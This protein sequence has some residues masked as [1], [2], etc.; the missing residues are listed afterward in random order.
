M[1]ESA[2]VG[3]ALSKAAYARQEPAL[4]DALLNAQFDLSQSGRGPVLMIISGVEGGGRSETTNKLTEWMDPRHVRVSAFGPRSCEEAERPPAWRYWR[5]LPAKGKLG[6]FLNAWYT[7]MVAARLAGTLDKTGFEFYLQETRLYERMLSDEGVVL[8]KFWIHLS[9]PALRARLDEFKRHDREHSAPY[10]LDYKRARDYRKLRPLWEEML[11]ETS[12]ADAPWTVV[13]GEDDRYRNI[14]V[15][16]VLLDAMT[17]IIPNEP[18]PA[19]RAIGAGPP[20][21]VVDNVRLVRELDLTKRLPARDYPEE[22]LKWQGRLAALTARKRFRDHALILAFEGVDAAGK[23]G[24]IRR[25]TGALDARQYVSVPIAAPTEEDKRYPYLWR[26]WRN[27]PPRGGITIFDRTWYGRVLVER[28]EGFCTEFD[29]RRAY[30]EINQFEEQ[31]VDDGGVL[32]K[33]W[34]QISKAE[35]YRRFK[36]R[37]K[38]SFKRFKIT[39]DDW[40]NRAK[41]NAYEQAVADMVDRTSSELAPWTL[42]EAEDKYFARIKILKTIVRR[43]EAAVN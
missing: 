14:T 17:R 32:C 28:V 3:H 8:L 25:V 39:P 33:F 19:R 26:F 40:R 43:L 20:P 7:E 21:S 34:L 23:G 27:V 22:L 42:I 4:R 2:E 9:R 11:R 5:A 12:T 15:G 31:L 6:I 37:E 38:T 16:K 1:L 24:A 35:Q 41:W 29:W 13:E 30:D 36:A 10:K 18:P